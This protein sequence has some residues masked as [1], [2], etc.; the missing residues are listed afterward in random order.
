M[1]G[2]RDGHLSGITTNRG[3][4]FRHSKAKLPGIF[5]Y[6]VF[7]LDILALSVCLRFDV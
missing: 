7:W 2:M 4:Q 5:G 1:H 6:L 3:F